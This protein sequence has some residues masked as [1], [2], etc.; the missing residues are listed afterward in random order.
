METNTI[1]VL[2]C[3]A[4][5]IIG[6]VLN[7]WPFGLTAMTVCLVLAATK[8]LT[9]EEAFS[10]FNNKIL[11][12]IAAMYVLSAGFGRTS[13]LANLQNKLFSLQ[14]KSGTLL[15]LGILGML[16][17]F[18]CFLPSVVIVALMIMFLQ[19]LG[20]S[21]EVSA[22][23]MIIL[24]A[25]IGAFWGGFLP[26][27][28]GL[29]GHLTLNAYYESLTTSPDQLVQM[30]DRFKF[31]LIPCGLTLLWCIFG[32]K[33]M[34]RD[35]KF[36]ASK[37]NQRQAAPLSK[38][39]ETVI[40]IAFF[41]TMG[42]LFF[43]SKLGN[44][45]YLIP[46]FAVLLIAF[47][48]TMTPKEILSAMFTDVT[49]MI[50]GIFVL[51]DAM[52][53]TGVGEMIGQLILKILGGNPTPLFAVFIFGLTALVMTSL[54]SN[55]ATGAILAPLAAATAIAAGW[56]PVPFVLITNRMSVCAIVLP[57]ASAA[58]GMAHA[59]SGL[60]LK[61]IIKFSLPFGLI[62]LLGCTLSAALFYL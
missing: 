17:I 6:L 8:V 39:Q 60:P 61:D 10:G 24:S 25:G 51:S 52:A 5:F 11:V 3:L 58:T 23:R 26:F 55:I 19:S 31:G 18:S 46:G 45:M 2:C 30:F 28:M 53:V 20:N 41:G 42:A 47:T 40:Y 14:G 9:I 33:V 54:M 36:D 44:F 34:P 37:G 22:S 43:S 49:M 29:T 27:G 1:I 38:K 16:I 12:M 59:A 50:A 13:L 7:K 15:L 48:K 57:S 56:N 32:Y 21:G 35:G 4:F 62:A